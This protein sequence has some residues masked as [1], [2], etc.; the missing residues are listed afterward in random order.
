[1]IGGVLGVAR[2][3]GDAALD[4]RADAPRGRKRGGT[5]L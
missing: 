4:V 2:P 5:A 1:M 3:G